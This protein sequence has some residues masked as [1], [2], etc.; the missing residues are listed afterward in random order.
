MNGDYA[1]IG[2]LDYANNEVGA[3]FI[4]SKDCGGDETFGLVDKISGESSGENCRI[5][6]IDGLNVLIGAYEK[7][8]T[9][10]GYMYVR[11]AP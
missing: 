4:Y 10:G 3:V 2:S 6:A 8:T 7:D 5:V 11:D 9:G 1:A